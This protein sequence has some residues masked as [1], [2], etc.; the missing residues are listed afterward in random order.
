MHGLSAA[1]Q[2]PFVGLNCSSV[3]GDLIEA[4]LFGRSSANAAEPDS[5]HA[6]LLAE[7]GE[8]ML[9]LD[10]VDALSPSL[11][12]MLLETIRTRR[13]RSV[14]SDESRA[15]LGR[16]V[17]ADRGKLEE[18]TRS[19]AFR[20]DL[21][22]ELSRSTLE[23]PRLEECRED[24]PK[25]VRQL[26]LR[27]SSTVVF[28]DD[29][30]EALKQAPWPGNSRQ[31]RQV[32][33]RV[34][35]QCGT[36]RV[37][38]A[39]L[40]PFLQA[41]VASVSQGATGDTELLREIDSTLEDC[42]GNVD[43]VAGKLG[44]RRDT[45]ERRLRSH[46]IRMIKAQSLC[47]KAAPLIDASQYHQALDLL[48]KALAEIASI[49]PSLEER[50]V[51]FAILE[52]QGVCHRSVSGW[53]SSDAI[54]NYTEALR[55][56]A[57]V[58]DPQKLSA[59]MFGKWTAQLTRLDL[60]TARDTANEIRLRAIALKNPEMELDAC[61]ALANTLFWLGEFGSCLH[62]IDRAYQIPFLRAT[63]N[64]RHGMTPIALVL[65]V[66]SLASQQIGD[67]ARL[68]SAYSRM[69]A[70]GD[71]PAHPF[72]QAIA[73]QGCCWIDS[74]RDRKPEVRACAERLLAISQEHGFVFYH[75]LGM[76]FAGYALSGSGSDD[77]AERMMRTGFN[78][79][80][81]S[82]GGILFHSAY[83]LFM[84]RHH[85]DCGDVDQAKSHASKGIRIAREHH[86]LA[87][88]AE[89][90]CLYARILHV[91]GDIEGAR[92][93]LREALATANGLGDRPAYYEANALLGSIG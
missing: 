63:D 19:G 8:G 61:M 81:A 82:N 69:A 58:V 49:P 12:E 30:L 40:A 59:L 20:A 9:Y 35:M 72:S 85:L 80:L 93:Q 57:R 52:R 64:S 60:S 89:L 77:E 75:G 7:T 73:L 56:G 71:D 66:D 62:A 2:A 65:L 48:D 6:G 84:S 37:D 78:D 87:Y 90:L 28:E 32:V 29:A 41:H 34:C 79:E 3:P 11:Q 86:E 5:Y 38:A 31:L 91:S 55:V 74:M 1:P 51:R 25:M 18:R 10:E 22:Q 44:I 23:I 83:S 21:F 54:E 13:Y 33:D 27:L 92:A 36:E 15:F 45:V 67:D 42:R 39:V 16:I 46:E 17:V 24:I 43:A 53:L 68:E 26:A 70:I 88:L 47:D 50:K 4:E 14:G 76:I